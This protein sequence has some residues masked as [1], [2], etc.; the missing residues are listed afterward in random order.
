MESTTIVVRLRSVRSGKCKR[1]TIKTTNTKHTVIVTG[2][3][4]HAANKVFGRPVF[5][6]PDRVFYTKI[7]REFRIKPAVYE[8]RFFINEMCFVSDYTLL[9]SY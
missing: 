3:N 1:N 6:R 4:Y 8:G 7:D 2:I 9:L 5:G